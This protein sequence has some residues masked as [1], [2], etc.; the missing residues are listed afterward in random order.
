MPGVHY[1][2]CATHIIMSPVA[3]YFSEVIGNYDETYCVI[4]MKL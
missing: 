4:M 2:E 1:K 3:I